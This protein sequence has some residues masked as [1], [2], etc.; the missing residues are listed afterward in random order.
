M[1]ELK[2][3]ISDWVS[4]TDNL[5]FKNACGELVSLEVYCR[6]CKTNDWLYFFK[7]H[8]NGSIAKLY[9]KDSCYEDFEFF[10]KEKIIWYEKNLSHFVDKNIKSK[11][12]VE[13]KKIKE[14]RLKL[15]FLQGANDADSILNKFFGDKNGVPH[16]PLGDRN[17]IS[18]IFQFAGFSKSEE[19]KDSKSEEFFAENEV[20]K[21]RKFL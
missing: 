14:N 1:R 13:L 16:D 5:K 2:T 17:M 9:E 20:I 6:R 12:K 4:A 19:S 3:E 8:R 11:I 10:L 15:S 21:R 18:H 7:C